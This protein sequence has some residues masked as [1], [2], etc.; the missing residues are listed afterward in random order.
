MNLNLT[1]L[2]FQH[3]NCLQKLEFFIIWKYLYGA[4]LEAEIAVVCN[5]YKNRLQL[6]IYVAGFD[7]F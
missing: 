3:S 1:Q 2:A 4:I 6:N 5:I 7:F